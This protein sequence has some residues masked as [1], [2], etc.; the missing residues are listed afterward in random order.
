MQSDQTRAQLVNVNYIS[1]VA[2]FAFTSVYALIK[3]TEQKEEQEL[4][5]I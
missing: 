2:Q 5:L 1:D 3:K 4:D